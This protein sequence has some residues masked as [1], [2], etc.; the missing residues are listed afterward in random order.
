MSSVGLGILRYRRVLR[1]SRMESSSGCF[2]P[3]QTMRQAHVDPFRADRLSSPVVCASS[4]AVII[5]SQAKGP[6]VPS[7]FG[8]N[9]TR[10]VP[11]P[12]NEPVKPYAPGSP[13]R[14]SLKARLASMADERIEIP[15]IIGGKEVTTG[16]LAKAVMPH[17]HGHVLADWHQ[18]S[19][20]HVRKAID[21]A[22]EARH[23]WARWPWEDRAAVFLKAAELL[24]THLARHAQRRDHARPVQDRLPGRDRRRLRADRLLALQRPL[25]AGALRR[26]AAV[27]LGHVEPAR[28]PAARGLRLRGDA[29]STS[30]R[31]PAT[32][33]PRRRSWAT[34]SSG[35][36]PRP[37]SRAAGTS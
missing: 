27:E 33:P 12:V 1:R 28:L 32:C 16:D 26:A 6:P 18:A 10:Q 22:A 35:S 4:T 13:E 37:R 30:P 2:S 8:F 17:D 5:V 7:D 29:R 19:G 20:E 11:P 23:E 34:P 25:R 15:L 9:G 24:A 36:R 31:S 14:A 3:L 21:A